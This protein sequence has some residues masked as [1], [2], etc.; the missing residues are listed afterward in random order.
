MC[1]VLILDSGDIPLNKSP[2]V[3][4]LHSNWDSEQ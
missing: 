2:G 1:Q 3:W 4:I